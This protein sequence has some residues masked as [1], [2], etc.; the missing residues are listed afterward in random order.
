M[1]DP[2]LAAQLNSQTE[3]AEQAGCEPEWGW[4]PGWAWALAWACPSLVQPYPLAAKIG[5]GSKK[6]EGGARDLDAG[7]WGTWMK[8]G[9]SD[10][11]KPTNF[12]FFVSNRKPSNQCP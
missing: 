11:S 5:G 2:G 10:T 3:K 12:Y 9:R 8:P 7:N 4:A 6:Q 1:A